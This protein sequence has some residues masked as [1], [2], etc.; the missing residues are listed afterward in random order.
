MMSK[1][2]KQTVLGMMLTLLLVGSPTSAACI[3]ERVIGLSCVNSFHM[4]SGTLTLV[5]VDPAINKAGVHENVTVNI[6]VTNVEDLYAWQIKLYFDPLLL[7]T[8]GAS[9]WYPPENVFDGSLLGIPA[10]VDTDVGGTYVMLGACL[11]YGQARFTGSGILCR[12]NF[13]VIAEGHSDLLFSRPLGEGQTFLLNS[14]YVGNDLIPF[15]VADGYV[16]T[17][18]PVNDVAVSGVRLSENIAAQGDILNV[19]VDVR[20][21]WNASRSANVTLFADAYTGIIGDEATLAFSNVSLPQFGLMTLPFS[22]NTSGATP[23]NLAISAKVESE[24]D[25]NATNDLLTDRTVQILPVFHDLAVTDIRPS[26]QA[27]YTGDPLNVDVN[28]QNLGDV[29][30][31]FNVTLYADPNTTIIGD[32]VIVGNQTVA[33]P[34]FSLTT[35]NYAW[36]TTDLTGGNYT[37]TAIATP[38]LGEANLDNNNMTGFVVELFETLPCPDVNVASPTALTINPSIF[39]YDPNLH[40]RLINI[41]NV[42]ITS[43]GFDGNLRV[44]GSTNGS[45]HLCVDQPGINAYPFYLPLDGEVQVPLWLVFQPE[46][47]WGY[48][49]G[50]YTLNVTVC[51]THR[52]QLTISGIDIDVCENGAYVVYNDTATFTWNLTGGSTV[53]LAAET[54]LPPGWTY[55]VDPPIGTFFETPHIVSLNITSPP[56]AKE[57]DVGR[58]TLRAYKNSTGMM[59]WQFI[60]FATTDPRP[61]T[62]ESVETPTLTLDGHF[63][64]NTTVR[65]S[66]GI[67]HVVLHTSVNGGP[68]ENVTMNWASGDTFNST[69]YTVQQ[70]FDAPSTLQYFVSAV[71]WLGNEASSPVQTVTVVSDVAVTGFSVL[72]IDQSE[73]Y[74]VNMS[75]VVANHGTLPL[76]LVNVAVYA[77]STLVATQ[78]LFDLQNGTSTTLDFSLNFSEGNYVLTACVASPAYESNTA[79]NAKHLDSILRLLHDVAVTNVTRFSRT[80]VGQ[81]YCVRLN[82]TVINSGGFDEIFNVTLKANE[83]IFQTQ[84]I[85]LSSQNATTVAFIWNTTD[86]AK[87]NY[88]ITAYAWPV[89]NETRI[90]D[91]NC[92]G[93]TIIVAIVGDITGPNGWPDG[94]CDMRDIRLVARGF[95]AIVVTDPNSPKCGQYWHPTPI[96]GDPCSPN[97]DITGPTSGVPDGTID[98][99]DIRIPAKNFGKTG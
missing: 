1:M 18:P 5:A 67:D 24:G 86:F 23:G 16:E 63:L 19:Q 47:H 13:T 99:R 80:V 27:L 94:T 77:N 51:G 34:R 33:M 70:A 46:T 65:S 48:Y 93:E 91:N 45:I 38:V 75:V 57:G 89:P 54:D 72:N 35:A 69:V 42:S 3:A 83:T 71:D 81:G 7:Y 11:I 41:G 60:Y 17:T 9:A 26:Q 52:I 29:A 40:A 30:E 25:V 58:V 96:K 21:Y 76:S 20:N 62:I 98:M 74:K 2:T 73:G 44:V 84:T 87:G 28:V 15:D 68:W 49:N 95:G 61:P 8:N 12:I 97:C 36:N 43:T 32:E 59:I 82:T 78:P 22:W 66:S 53:Y 56:D 39:D 14:T 79:D 64:F 55:T 88:T 10:V 90:A 37:L 4:T 31:A 92:S 85:A 6:N 50:T